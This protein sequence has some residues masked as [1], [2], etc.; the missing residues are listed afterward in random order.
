MD[1]L[2]T[3]EISRFEIDDPNGSPRSFSITFGFGDNEYFEDKVLEKKFW[4]RKSA[5]WEGLVSEPV[6][7]NWKKG[8]D[9]TGGLTDAAYQLAQA[10]RK[11]AK[12]FSGDEKPKES[13]V[14]EFKALATKI[15]ESPSAS[16]SFFAWF[17]F[18]SSFRWISAQESEEADKKDR[19]RVEKLKR[20]DKV[21]DEDEAVPDFEDIDYQEVEVFPQGDEIAT[22]IAEDLWPSAI[23]YYSTFMLEPSIE[24]H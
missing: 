3:L 6:K 9:L 12:T 4:F 11:L 18:V 2:E 24:Q 19:E 7:I 13:D 17:G 1:C 8:Q 5:D 10:R 20:G 16:L 21:E 15:E 14:P 23:K 22:L